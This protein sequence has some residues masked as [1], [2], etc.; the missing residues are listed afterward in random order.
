MSNMKSLDSEA[1]MVCLA[2]FM[3]CSQGWNSK[4]P[5]MQFEISTI[6]TSK[7]NLHGVHIRTSLKTPC[8]ILWKLPH[9]RN[10]QQ[11]WFKKSHSTLSLGLLPQ[12]ITE[13]RCLESLVNNWNYNDVLLNSF[14]L[15][16]SRARFSATTQLKVRT[17]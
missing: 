14:H 9:E 6:S 2:A 13:L 17:S 5:L 1:Y 16:N 7:Q 15:N 8:K 10:A 11:L 12:K 3:P 4:D